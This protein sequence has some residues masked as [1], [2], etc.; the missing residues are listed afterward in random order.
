MRCSKASAAVSVPIAAAFAFL[1]DLRNHWRLASR[2][3]EVVSLTPASGPAEAAVVQLNGPLRLARTVHTRVDHFA[4]PHT[5]QGH[6]TAG[7]TRAAVTWTLERNRD[8]TLVSV[9]VQLTDAS[10]PDRLIWHAG[11]RLWLARRLR[12]TLTGLEEVLTSV[13]GA[14]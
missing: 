5:I 9:A 13:P 6:G 12:Q 1:A 10:L 14:V 8:R 7:R 2:W 11:G 4:E 3:I